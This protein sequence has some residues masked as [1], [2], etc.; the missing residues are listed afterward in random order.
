MIVLI[1]IEFAIKLISIGTTIC[2]NFALYPLYLANTFI[3]IFLGIEFDIHKY[4]KKRIISFSNRIINLFSPK[5]IF[6]NILYLIK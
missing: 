3:K 1:L 5:H 2:I 4:T 6:N